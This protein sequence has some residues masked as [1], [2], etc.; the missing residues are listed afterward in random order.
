MANLTKAMLSLAGIDA[1]LTWVGT[2]RIPYSYEIPSLAVDNHMICTVFENN[3]LKYILDPTENFN[4]FKI[5]SENI[6]G[7]QI[8]IENGK[9]YIISTVN[10]EP[11][12]KYRNESTWH[13][14]INNNVLLGT[15]KTS[16]DGEVKKILFN[17]SDNIKKE[18]L[19]KFFRQVIAGNSNPDNFKVMKYSAF[20]RDNL[21]D[22]SYDI[23]LKNQVYQNNK[24]L[25]VD[26][27][28][29]KDYKNEKLEKDRKV[30]YKFM[31]RSCK[32]TVAGNWKFPKD[33]KSIICPNLTGWR[34]ATSHSI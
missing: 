22:I 15:G 24:E 33:I 25:Y 9:S 34:T 21:W 19:D 2:Q 18:D 23:N 29:E 3:Q 20:D 6:Q 10:E 32:K 11:I 4:P 17:V 5:N 26:V 28:F 31:S 7:K 13:F 8:M 27:D 14:T 16:L 12:E 1:R 30:P